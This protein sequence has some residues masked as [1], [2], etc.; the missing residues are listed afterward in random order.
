V[1]S[2]P[3][4]RQTLGSKQPSNRR[5]SSSAWVIKDRPMKQVLGLTRSCGSAF[6]PVKLSPDS[7]AAAAS[8]P[9]PISPSSTSA[10]QFLASVSLSVIS[11]YPPLP[12]SLLS[13]LL[14]VDEVLPLFREPANQSKPEILPDP[15]AAAAFATSGRQAALRG[16]R[17]SLRLPSL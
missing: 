11:T 7:S 2:L 6:T 1:V 16:L 14:E 8:L 3:G 9:S 5:G 13:L 4:S 15:E 12:E 10:T 17:G